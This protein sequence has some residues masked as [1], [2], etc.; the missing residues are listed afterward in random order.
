MVKF[1]CANTSHLFAST[2]RRFSNCTLKKTLSMN[3][4]SGEKSY[5]RARWL[6]E[7]GLRKG[8][9]FQPEVSFLG[10]QQEKKQKFPVRTPASLLSW[11][12]AG[13]TCTRFFDVCSA[14]WAS[15]WFCSRLCTDSG[16][17]T[18]YRGAS[19]TQ[20]AAAHRLYHSSC[21]Q[22]PLS[23]RPR[24]QYKA[25]AQNNQ[26]YCYSCVWGSA[27]PFRDINHNVGHSPMTCRVNSFWQLFQAWR[28]F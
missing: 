19:S 16:N 26:P 25:L 18:R 17:D 22:K 9:A 7:C 15:W 6:L 1:L 10:K 27:D 4:H 2:S 21:H 11:F 24:S 5:P 3:K 20:R 8:R 14:A 23:M 13:L 28:D 12:P